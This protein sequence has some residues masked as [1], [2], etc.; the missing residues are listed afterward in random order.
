MKKNTERSLGMLESKLK[1]ARR[2]K[3]TRKAE[4]ILEFIQEVRRQNRVDV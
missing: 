2:E 4:Q 1:A 3:K